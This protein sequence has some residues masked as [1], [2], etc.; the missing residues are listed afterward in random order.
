M[1]EGQSGWVGIPG[2]FVEISLEIH[3]NVSLQMHQECRVSQL[4][5]LA[6][7][8]TQVHI[9]R[10]FFVLSS[11]SLDCISCAVKKCAIP[12]SEPLDD[13]Q[14][15]LKW[16]KEIDVTEVE[17]VWSQGNVWS[18]RFYFSGWPQNENKRKWKDRY[19]LELCQRA[20]PHPD[21]KQTNIRVTVIPTVVDA[22]G[23]VPKGKK[24]LEELEMRGRAE[25]I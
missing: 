19:I 25:T 3:A 4:S 8:L 2:S 11:H 23:T 5:L 7:E 21:K 24:K 16:F 12:L 17:G 22:L 15:R 6:L 20:E 1:R 9:L 10:L 18:R 14:P 13:H